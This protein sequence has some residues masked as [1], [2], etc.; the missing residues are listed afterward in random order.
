M[1]IKRGVSCGVR[2]TAL[3]VPT[4]PPR[5]APRQWDEALGRD[6]CVCVD[7]GSR[8][9]SVFTV[10]PVFLVRCGWGFRS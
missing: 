9:G 4:R 2:E 3:S 1:H 7:S 6:C 5:R 10:P 8:G